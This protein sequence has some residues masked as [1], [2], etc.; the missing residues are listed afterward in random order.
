METTAG[1]PTTFPDASARHGDKPIIPSYPS[2][3]DYRSEIT[4]FIVWYCSDGILRSDEDI[5]NAVF[6]EL[7]FGRRGRKIVE[8]INGEILVLRKDGRIP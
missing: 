8:R 5:F 2:I 3:D 6:D 1:N 7:P 4:T